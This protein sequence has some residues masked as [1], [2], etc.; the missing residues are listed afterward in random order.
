MERIEAALRNAAKRGVAVELLVSE[1]MLRPASLPGLQGLLR[2][3]GVSVKLVTIPRAA[4]GEIPFARLI[5]AK[6]TVVDG[7]EIWIGTS[8][9][10]DRYFLNS[11][12][13]SLFIDSAQLGERLDRI[14]TEL[15]NSP[16]AQPMHALAPSGPPP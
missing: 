16:Y 6:Y 2:T 7:H 4:Q 8:N 11:R 12:N 3:P 1:W 13:V 14:W 15:W 9:W 10:E 5:H